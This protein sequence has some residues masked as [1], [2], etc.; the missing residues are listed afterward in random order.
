MATTAQGKAAPILWQP[1]PGSQTL[2]LTCPFFECLYEGTRGPGKSAALLMDFGQ[3]VGT[4][5]GAS[6]RGII[7]RRE[8]KELSDLVVK[9]RKIFGDVFPKARFLKSPAEYKWIWPTGEELL[10]RVGVTEEDYWAYHGHEYPFIG[11]DEMCTWPDLKFYHAM[12]SVCRSTN[13]NAPRK[14][15]ATANPYGPGHNVVKAYYIDPAPPGVPVK[16]DAGRMRVRIFG[17]IW[18]NSHLLENDPDYVK[19]LMAEPNPNKRKAWLE[20]SWDVVAGG[21]FDDMWRE[22]VHVIRPFAIPKTWRI[23][24]SF[25]WGS[26]HPFSVGWW[27]ESDGSEVET[28]TG[29]RTFPRGTLFR[30]AEWYGWNGNPNEGCRMLAKDIAKGILEREAEMGL[31]PKRVDPGPADTSI[32]DEENGVCIATDMENVGVKWTRA[33][34]SPGSRK[35]GWEKLRSLLTASMQK[36]MEDPGLFVFST[37]RQFIRTVP[38]LPRSDRD[39]DDVD[40]AAEDHVADEVRYRVLAPPLPIIAR[41]KPA[42]GPIASVYTY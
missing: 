17:T 25:D 31:P 2:F 41:V 20:G 26:S 34:K 21:M 6:W 33:N 38:V 11:F 8:Y 42:S 13:P 36:P 24:R 4:G 5:L 39:P 16:D 1:L 10:F 15:R 28:S 37:C 12:K 27:A 7:F 14:I 29:K 18:E 9:S 30:I 32:F 3:H 19:T 23:D 35:Q 40:T 22:G